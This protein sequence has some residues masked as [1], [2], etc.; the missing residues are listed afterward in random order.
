M[1]IDKSCNSAVVDKFGGIFL[2]ISSMYFLLKYFIQQSYHMILMK[3][4]TFTKTHTNP[5]L[6]S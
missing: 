5:T 3:E 1:D 6:K 4:K 2:I